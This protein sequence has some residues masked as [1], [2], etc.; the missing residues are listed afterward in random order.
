MRLT[1]LKNPSAWCSILE[2]VDFL[3][4]VDQSAKQGAGRRSP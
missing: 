4:L 2:N 1:A 3:S